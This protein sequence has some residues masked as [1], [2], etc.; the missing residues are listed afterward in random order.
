MRIRFDDRRGGGGQH[1]L[2]LSQRSG[3]L[4]QQRAYLLGQI[5]PCEQPRQIHRA[6][7]IDIVPVDEQESAPGQRE[8]RAPEDIGLQRD[9][10]TVHLPHSGRG[11][12]F[13]QAPRLLRS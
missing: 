3:Y 6:A 8:A 9:V 4:G 13:D 11:F 1:R 2:L 10:M 12:H 7:S 5:F